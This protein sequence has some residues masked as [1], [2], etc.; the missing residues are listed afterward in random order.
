MEKGKVNSEIAVEATP[1]KTNEQ[2]K[3]EKK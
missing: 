1:D 3:E 2:L